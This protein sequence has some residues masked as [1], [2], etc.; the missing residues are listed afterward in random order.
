MVIDRRKFIGWAAAGA[1][2][3]L[4]GC[5][6]GGYVPPTRLVWLLNL[7]PEFPA[8][9]VSFGATPVS[10]GL[11]FTGL[12]ARFEVEYGL[13]TVSLRRSDGFTVNFDNVRI[14]DQSPSVFVFYRHFNSSRLGPSPAGIENYFDSTVAL[15]VEL[16]NGISSLPQVEVL[17]FE[18]NAPQDSS[19]LDCI[20]HLYARGSSTRIYDSGLQERTDSILIFPRFPATHARSGEVAVI[21]LNYG[22]GSATAVEWLNLLG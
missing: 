18:G 10:A 19:S 15:D 20:L 2:T 5:G 13:Y 21:G 6:G 1:G 14:D 8:M 22:F 4:T 3:A 9:D 16:F 17:P 11:P 12:T 7:N